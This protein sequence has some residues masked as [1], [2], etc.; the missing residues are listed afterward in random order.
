MLSLLKK[1]FSSKKS[2]AEVLDPATKLW[3]FPPAM[4]AVQEP[5][6]PVELTHVEPAPAVA[7]KPKRAPAV[8]KPKVATKAP[9]TRKP[10]VPRAPQ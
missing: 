1:L 9:A 8:K 6:A 4:P 5:E 7:P 3:P 2:D 10:R